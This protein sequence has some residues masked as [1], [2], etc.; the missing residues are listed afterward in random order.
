[1]IQWAFRAVAAALKVYGFSRT[2]SRAAQFPCPE[3]LELE[4]PSFRTKSA[5]LYNYR[6]RLRPVAA[7]E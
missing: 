3:I 7:K 6:V 2:A 4:L 5:R 1:L